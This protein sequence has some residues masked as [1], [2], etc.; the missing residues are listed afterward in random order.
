MFSFAPAFGF[1]F[2]I[3]AYSAIL[4]S[5]NTTKNKSFLMNTEMDLR[6]ISVDLNSYPTDEIESTRNPIRVQRTDFSKYLRTIAGLNSPYI[7]WAVIFISLDLIFTLITLVVGSSNLSA[8]PIEPRIP[9]YLVVTGSINLVSLSFTIVAYFLHIREKDDNLIGFFYVTCSAIMI[10]IFQL[11]NFIWLICGTVWLFSVFNQVE[12]T[13]IN[14]NTY[15][16]QYIYQYTLVSIIL[17]YIIPLGICCCK[18]APL[19]K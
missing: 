16:Q 6:S 8:C 12:Y 2:V 18:T 3:Y 4:K 17:Q 5:E 1:F 15:C 10:I 19:L 11:F 7:P 9:I 13:Q 14:E